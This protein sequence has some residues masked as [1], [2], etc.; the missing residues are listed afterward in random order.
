L[1]GGFFLE[2]TKN[3]GLVGIQDGASEVC[4]AR[5][6]P[7]VAVATPCRTTLQE[8]LLD[9]EHEAARR[10][11]VAK[12]LRLFDAQDKERTPTMVHF[13]HNTHV[14]RVE[15]DSHGFLTVR[16]SLRLPAKVLHVI[17]FRKKPKLGVIYFFRKAGSLNDLSV[18]SGLMGTL[19][20]QA[21]THLAG[22]AQIY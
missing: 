15:D 21:S 14:L 20:E 22:K 2:W 5:D 16:I 1:P 10:E 17:R 19:E 13:D 8:I 6:Y 4:A 9:H 18:E 12:V 3:A 7:E 11:G